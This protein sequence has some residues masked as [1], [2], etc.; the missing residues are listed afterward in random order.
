LSIVGKQFG[1]HFVQRSGYGYLSASVGRRAA[2]EVSAMEQLLSAKWTLEDP[3]QKR[4]LSAR[5]GS[6]NWR[7]V[8]FPRQSREQLV[9]ARWRRGCQ[10]RL[11]PRGDRQ[12]EQ[13][14]EG[15]ANISGL[16]IFSLI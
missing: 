16:H 5:H 8:A 2:A 3:L 11:F 7:A 13:R 15:K 10:T 1:L 12:S 9:R 6:R 14:T 4:Y